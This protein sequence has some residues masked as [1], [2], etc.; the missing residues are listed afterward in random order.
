MPTTHSTFTLT[1]TFTHT[2]TS[3]SPHISTTSHLSQKLIATSYFPYEIFPH[4]TKVFAAGVDSTAS[5]QHRKEKNRDRSGQFGVATTLF[6]R[7]S[8]RI[9]CS[10]MDGKS[11]RATGILVL[12]VCLN[13]LKMDS[14]ER[15]DFFMIL[16]VRRTMGVSRRIRCQVLDAMRVLTFFA[17]NPLAADIINTLP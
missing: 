12:T 8:E 5:L 13:Y 7:I 17:S 3:H 4:C 14:F 9:E 2:T 16:R 10:C 15:K 11:I 6:A 1:L